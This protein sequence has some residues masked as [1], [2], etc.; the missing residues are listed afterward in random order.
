MNITDNN[1]ILEATLRSSASLNFDTMSVSDFK[2]YVKFTFPDT[3]FTRADK[4]LNA[5]DTDFAKNNDNSMLFDN[6]QRI[7]LYH[8]AGLDNEL[9]NQ[10]ATHIAMLGNVPTEPLHVVNYNGGKII[11]EF[12][13]VVAS[14][15]A[16]KF[17]NKTATNAKE[18]VN[19]LFKQDP[20]LKED[21][22]RFGIKI[23][24][25]EASK[26]TKPKSQDLSI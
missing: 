2:R 17:A 18:F 25:K 14:S 10:L 6:A 22:S 12:A 15:E 11:A 19:A 26:N 5:M 3:D 7:Y 1:T 13:E 8:Y 16:V 20:T 24:D 4:I 23:N 9:F 21:F